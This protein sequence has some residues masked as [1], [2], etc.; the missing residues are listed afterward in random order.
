MD[1]W[2]TVS[3]LEETVWPTP[4]LAGVEPEG[5]ETGQDP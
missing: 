5:L 1:V 4:H 2:G 3:G